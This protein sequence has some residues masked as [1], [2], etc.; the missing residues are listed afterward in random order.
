M[1][2]HISIFKVLPKDG[3][4]LLKKAGVAGVFHCVGILNS[5]CKILD[6]VWSTVPDRHAFNYS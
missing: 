4:T 1:D 6:N 5:I 3:R 2:L